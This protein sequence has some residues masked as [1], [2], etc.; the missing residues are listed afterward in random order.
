MRLCPPTF[1]LKENHPNPLNM[2]FKLRVLELGK[3]RQINGVGQQ[4]I[5][6]SIGDGGAQRGCEPGAKQ[7]QAMSEP[8]L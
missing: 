2:G 7:G 5:V 8:G 1:P 6:Q 3:Y 4:Q